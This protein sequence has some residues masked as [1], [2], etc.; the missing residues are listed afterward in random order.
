MEI[1]RAMCTEPLYSVLGYRYLYCM[2]Y[3]IYTEQ[4]LCPSLAH[5]RGLPSISYLNDEYQQCVRA[6]GPDG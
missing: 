6:R 2:G 4:Y 3:R 5:E 1:K